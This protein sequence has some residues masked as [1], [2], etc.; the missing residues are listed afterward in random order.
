MEQ[1]SP[2]KVVEVLVSAAQV[3]TTIA[4]AALVVSCGSTGCARTTVPRPVH[5]S[6]CPDAGPRAGAKPEPAG[7]SGQGWAVPLQ[8]C[9]FR[10]G[11]RLCNASAEP[12][13]MTGFWQVSPAEV[14]NIDG[15]LFAF[16]RRQQMSADTV[17]SLAQYGRQYLGFFRGTRQYVFIHAFPPDLRVAREDAE[18]EVMAV[19]DNS[20]RVEYDV[21]AQQFAN[22][23]IDQGPSPPQ[24]KI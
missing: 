15:A 22:F 4:I 14:A 10:E 9:A 6:K 13:G 11:F 5:N 12:T 3:R 20:W 1:G 19:C 17:R 7:T 23:A 16:L 2:P 8:L 18:T 24:A 21:G